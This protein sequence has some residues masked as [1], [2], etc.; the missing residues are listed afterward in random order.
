MKPEVQNHLV[1]LNV[2]IPI[3]LKTLYRFQY[4]NLLQFDVIRESTEA[5]I[6]G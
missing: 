1:L 5:Y 3:L 6:K 2:T 4:Y